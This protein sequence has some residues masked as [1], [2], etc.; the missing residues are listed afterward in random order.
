[1]KI[2][3]KFVFNR[4]QSDKVCLYFLSLFALTLFG[5]RV[6]AA[7]VSP[8]KEIVQ[9]NENEKAIAGRIE[10]KAKNIVV[11]LASQR[12]E[13]L[14]NTLHPA[15]RDNWPASKI[16]KVWSELLSQTGSFIKLGDSRI[17]ETINGDLVFVSVE[18][19][20]TTDELLVNFN[21][22]E[23]IV[24]LDFPKIE[25][26]EQISTKVVGFLAEKD[27]ASARGYLHPYL[28]KEIF[29]QQVEQKWEELLLRT[30][31]FQRQVNVQA[32]NRNSIENMNVVLVTIDFENLTDELIVIF[33]N[34]K[35]I[36]GLDFPVI[37]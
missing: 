8:Q 6:F 14:R 5:S 26:I 24:G 34:D 1:M 3:K 27:F 11:L 9:L 4:K 32:R 7:P 2:N 36:I 12:Y 29:P 17:V 18:F 28:K 25:T 33:D 10:Q 22:Y 31:A 37:D 13:I 23:Q 30:G 19:R 15:L 21:Q 16:E 20:N 35:R